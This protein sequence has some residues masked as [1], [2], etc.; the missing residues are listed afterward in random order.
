[1]TS[2]E[3][4]PHRTAET[5]RNDWNLKTLVEELRTSREETHRVRHKSRIRELPSSEALK[6]IT[7]DLAAALFRVQRRPET[8]WKFAP[9]SRLVWLSRTGAERT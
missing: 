2:K 5:I 7:V 8:V 6:Q 1:M 3:S 4:N 9:G